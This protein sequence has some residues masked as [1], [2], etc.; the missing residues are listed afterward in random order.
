MEKNYPFWSGRLAGELAALIDVV[1]RTKGT[2]W[3]VS[4]FEARRALTEFN[5]WCDE[6]R[7]QL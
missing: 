6:R 7:V 4:T 1:E 5:R 3:T 2:T